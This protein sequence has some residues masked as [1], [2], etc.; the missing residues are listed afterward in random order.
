MSYRN[1]LKHVVIGVDCGLDRLY[2]YFGPEDL[3][4]FKGS[5]EHFKSNPCFAYGWRPLTKKEFYNKHHKFQS[6]WSSD[7]GGQT[8]TVPKETISSSTD[9]IY[10]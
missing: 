9:S 4:E 5:Y 1:Y 2:G 6:R 3:V 8:K 10:E 7:A